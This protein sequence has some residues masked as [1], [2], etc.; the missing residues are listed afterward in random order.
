MAALPILQKAAWRHAPNVLVSEVDDDALRAELMFQVKRR[1]TGNSA[2]DWTTVPAAFWVVIASSD[3]ATADGTDRWIDSGDLVWDIEGNA[4]SW[5]HLRLVDYFGAG[6]HLEWVINL[7]AVN[8]GAIGSYITRND[9]GAQFT[10]G[11]T[12]GTTT[13]RPTATAEVE[14]RPDA[15]TTA[16]TAGWMGLDNAV[17]ITRRFS[18]FAS[19]DAREWRVAM[20]GGGA[21]MAFW[22][23][24]E[25][26]GAPDQDDTG[27]AGWD[28]PVHFLIL[29]LDNDGEL[30]VPANLSIGAGDD[31]WP[32]GE[33]NT[34][35]TYTC[36]VGTKSITDDQWVTR[37]NAANAFDG[38]HPFEDVDLYIDTSQAKPGRMGFVKDLWWGIAVGTTADDFPDDASRQFVYCGNMILPWIGDGTLLN[39]TA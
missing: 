13:S 4:H 36:F 30:L 22:A 19:S 20:F 17:P 27:V 37:A 28:F 18:V 39:A 15:G 25:L 1:L 16:A 14:V 31:H 10:T 32:V 8:T 9:G 33:L 11:F 7:S 2:G 26:T 12:F 34:P 6:D 5:I 21:C 24:G 23:M 38:A 29:S 3:S 35:A